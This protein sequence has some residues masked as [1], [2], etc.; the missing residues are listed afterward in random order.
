VLGSSKAADLLSLL[1]SCR[2]LP[3]IRVAARAMVPP[4]E[5]AGATRPTE[6]I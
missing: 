1:Q 4:P 6:R 2:D 3:D 5:R